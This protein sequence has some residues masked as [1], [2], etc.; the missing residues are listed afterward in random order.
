MTGL[1][2]KLRDSATSDFDIRNAAW[3][4]ADRIEQLE[5]K[6]A[7]LRKDAERYQWVANNIYFDG[8][9]WYTA[10]TL[11]SEFRESSGKPT[12]KQVDDSIDLEMKEE[13]D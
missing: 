7:E 10:D 4:A 5:C 9:A 3:D 1:V 12:K 11:I 2:E 6:I 8:Y 13:N